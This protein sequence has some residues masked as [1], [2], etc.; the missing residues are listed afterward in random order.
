MND[1]PPLFRNVEALYRIAATVVE[2]HETVDSE[3]RH[4]HALLEYE[5]NT[6]ELLHSKATIGV[7]V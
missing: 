2:V 3:E 1:R 6:V 4:K 5:P 7:I